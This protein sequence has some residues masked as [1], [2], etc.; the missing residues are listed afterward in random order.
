M[1]KI[2]YYSCYCLT[3]TNAQTLIVGIYESDRNT[4][5]CSIH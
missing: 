3:V 5:G 2:F 4:D 1:V